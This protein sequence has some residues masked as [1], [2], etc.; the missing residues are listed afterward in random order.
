M[1]QNKYKLQSRIVYPLACSGLVFFFTTLF[2][3]IPMVI[4]YFS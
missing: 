1:Y 4:S 3:G 2:V